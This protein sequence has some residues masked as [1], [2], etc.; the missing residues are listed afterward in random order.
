MDRLSVTS[1]F[2]MS[3]TAVRHVLRSMGPALIA[4]WTCARRMSAASKRSL[5]AIAS[6]AK[7]DLTFRLS[8]WESHAATESDLRRSC[9]HPWWGSPGLRASARN[10]AEA[11][12]AP[13]DG[14]D[15]LERQGDV[16]DLEAGVLL[17][18]ADEC[19]VVQHRLD[20]G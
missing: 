12:V 9:W 1:N 11:G 5:P 13:A 2:W 4:S 16:G 19:V 18:R 17:R 6:A 20:H 14:H 8:L 10:V 15:L 3:F 7:V